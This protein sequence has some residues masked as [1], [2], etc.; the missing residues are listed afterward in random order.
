M[1]LEVTLSPKTAEWLEEKAKAAG[2]DE[3][4]VAARELQRL[5]EQELGEKRDR[6]AQSVEERLAEFDR[7]TK[8]LPRCGGKADPSRDT[9]YD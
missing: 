1:T 8:S 9:I 2:T 4:A 5:A 7:W 6:A 3:A